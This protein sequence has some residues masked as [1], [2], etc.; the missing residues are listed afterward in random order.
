VWAAPTRSGHVEPS[1][2]RKLHSEAFE[3]MTAESEKLGQRG[4]AP[5][6]LYSLRHTFLTRLGESGCDAWTLAR[7]AGHNSIAVSARYDLPR[8]EKTHCCSSRIYPGTR[9]SLELFR[10]PIAQRR[11]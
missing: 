9:F 8:P 6:V 11:M 5:F 2:L 3:V 1:S 10:R 7:I 4:V